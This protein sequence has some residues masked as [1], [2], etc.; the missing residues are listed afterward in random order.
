MNDAGPIASLTHGEVL[1]A[2]FSFQDPENDTRASWSGLS[3]TDMSASYP[4]MKARIGSVTVT[5]PHALA[6][7]NEVGAIDT[8]LREEAEGVEAAS[9]IIRGAS[10]KDELLEIDRMEMNAPI[11]TVALT[12][13][14]LNLAGLMK[15]DGTEETEVPE[16]E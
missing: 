11:A 4:E 5:S 3:V 16:E 2:D 9:M 12:D 6:V 15:S 10:F 8:P 7:R 14:G 13:A 1:V